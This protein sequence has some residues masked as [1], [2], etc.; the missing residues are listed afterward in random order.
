MHGKDSVGKDIKFL[1]CVGVPAA[2]AACE[3]YADCVGFTFT[4]DPDLTVFYNCTPD[5]SL[6]WLKHAVDMGAPSFPHPNSGLFVKDQVN[7]AEASRNE[8]PVM[9]PSLAA[10]VGV[11]WQHRDGGL[12][13]GGC[14]F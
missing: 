12:D 7:M 3:S 13:D 1:P 6:V 11:D 2:K 14:L 8:R 4:R 9:P 10:S 5:E